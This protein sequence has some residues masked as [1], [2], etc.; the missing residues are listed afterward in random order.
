MSSC[1][2]CERSNRE[3]MRFCT[4]CG[5]SLSDA[6]RREAPAPDSSQ[7]YEPTDIADFSGVRF[8]QEQPPRRPIRPATIAAAIIVLV[9]AAAGAGAGWW[10]SGGNGSSHPGSVPPSA[11]PQAAGNHSSGA[12]SSPPPPG[13]AS[14]PSTPSSPSPSATTSDGTVAVAPAAA[15]DPAVQSVATFLAEYFSSINSH[16]FQEFIALRSPAAQQGLTQAQF[17]SGY[18]GTVDSAE[19]LQSS[20]TATN[21]DTVAAV[22]FTSHQ[23]PDSADNEESCTN[24]SISLFL[25]AGDNGYLIDDPPPAY[26]ASSTSCL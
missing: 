6:D 26:H 12:A 17:D 23:N 7:G 11:T 16:D 1:P 2:A 8:R 15:Q 4:G 5:T 24:W 9:L 18:N 10:L 25:E 22:T 14:S 21:G 19:T 13:T 20:S 3:G